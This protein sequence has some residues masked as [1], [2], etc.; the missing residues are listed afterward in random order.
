M[1]PGRGER[2][3]PSGPSQQLGTLPASADD[4]FNTPA[5]DKETGAASIGPYICYAMWHETKALKAKA[6][7]WPRGWRGQSR[8][9]YVRAPT[10]RT[11]PPPPAGTRKTTRPCRPPA[12][13]CLAGRTR[14]IAI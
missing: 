9:P 3:E 14:F 1:A 4:V 2:A 11:G 5:F 10:D 8:G 6:S 13:R 12:V 7:R